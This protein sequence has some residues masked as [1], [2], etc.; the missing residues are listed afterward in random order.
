MGIPGVRPY[1]TPTGFRIMKRVVS[2]VICT[3]VTL[4]SL[5]I[6]PEAVKAG[7]RRFEN[8]L[9]ICHDGDSYTVYQSGSIVISG[10]CATGARWAHW[11]PFAT[12]SKVHKA[13]CGIPL[14]PTS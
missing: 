7:C 11:L 10:D 3:A 14:N 1:T 13:L 12:A 4:S 9:T 6:F 5:A 8:D 2:S